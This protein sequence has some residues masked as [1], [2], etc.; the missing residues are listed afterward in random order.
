LAAEIGDAG[1][2][3]A[4]RL[5]AHYY[6]MVGAYVGYHDAFGSG[7]EPARTLSL[8][9]DLRPA[10]VPRWAENLEQGPGWVDLAVDSVS[11][12]LGVF[13]EQAAAVSFGAQRG[14]EGSLGFGLPLFGTASGLWFGL[15]ANL[16]WPEL[17]GMAHR[18]A[19]AAAILTLEWHHL[20]VTGLVASAAGG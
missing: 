3:S 13:W 16:R 11:L 5:S 18:P 9:I 4:A 17:A 8:G 14:L 1:A 20:V 12:G 10:F 2:R 7:V 6:S 15:R 19:A